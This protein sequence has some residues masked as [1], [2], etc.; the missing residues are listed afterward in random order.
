MA[1]LSKDL[2]LSFTGDKCCYC[3]QKRLINSRHE[4]VAELGEFIQCSICSVI[5]PIVSNNSEAEDFSNISECSVEVSNNYKTEAIRA[6][7]LFNEH[8]VD[9]E[10]IFTFFTS[11]NK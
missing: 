8:L 10:S 3:N 6:V 11:C 7:E 1:V 4:S 9:T 2:T 5:P